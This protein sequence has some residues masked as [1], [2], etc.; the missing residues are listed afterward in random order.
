MTNLA[1]QRLD[2]PSISEAHYLLI[3]EIDD[4]KDRIKLIRSA[5]DSWSD[6]NA[7]FHALTPPKEVVA[8]WDKI[9][10]WLNSHA[11]ATVNELEILQDFER[12]LMF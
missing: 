2:P 9:G 7:D 6:F 4:A 10:P 3:G 5:Q 8:A 12:D 1:E 11:G